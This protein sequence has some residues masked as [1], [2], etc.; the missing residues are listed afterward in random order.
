MGTS[1]MFIVLGL[2]SRISLC[3]L[4]ASPPSRQSG[5]R[6][7]AQLSNAAVDAAR[8]IPGDDK[9]QRCNSEFA[10]WHDIYIA[11]E[12]AGEWMRNDADFKWLCHE[13]FYH[14]RHH[15]HGGH[16]I[17]KLATIIWRPD[18]FK[19]SFCGDVR[20]KF[21]LRKLASFSWKTRLHNGHVADLKKM[22]AWI[23]KWREMKFWCVNLMQPDNSNKVA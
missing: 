16:S 2:Y 8:L 12:C 20:G 17:G 7:V 11:E 15:I 19:V 21:S 23:K 1:I 10:K 5:P 14:V 6:E 9:K 22:L 13:W 3:I 18:S 4:Q